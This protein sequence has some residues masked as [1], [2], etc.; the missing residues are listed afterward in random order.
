MGIAPDASQGSSSC[1][2][3]PSNPTKSTG[4]RFAA[5]ASSSPIR[6]GLSVT[7]AAALEAAALERRGARCG[8]P[9]RLAGVAAAADGRERDGDRGGEG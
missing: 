3:A 2:S 1:Q 5:R 6:R 7:E 9:G 8:G 4:G